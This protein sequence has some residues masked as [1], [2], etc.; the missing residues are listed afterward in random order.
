M[1][2]FRGF[3]V[4][5]LPFF[6]SIMAHAQKEYNGV[7]TRTSP[8]GTLFFQHNKYS[9][10]MKKILLTFYVIMACAN[11]ALG[12]VTISTS[13]LIGTKWQLLEDYECH[14]SEYY[15]FTR[16]ALIWHCSDGDT[17]SYPYYLTNTKPA[18]FVMK[19]VG[20]IAKGAYFAKQIDNYFYNCYA[21]I[22]F[23]KDAGKMVHR[24][25]YP[26]NVIGLTDTFTYILMKK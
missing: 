10:Q 19:K 23:D 12:Q 6:C 16:D 22:R 18:S 15:E 4:L 20:V 14:S 11:I 13:D 17:I 7:M 21:I 1:K 3:I 8:H 24:R 9:V 26:T 5:L 25:V 2:S